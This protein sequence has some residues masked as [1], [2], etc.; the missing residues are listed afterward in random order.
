MEQR[1]DHP[2]DE[3][4]D[5]FPSCL[6]CPLPKCIEEAPK[7]RRQVKLTARNKEIVELRQK[8]APIEIIA[9]RYGIGR[10]MVFRILKRG[11]SWEIIAR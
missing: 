9:K 5:L 11:I 1:T 7:E 6:N 3:G 8:G 2:G 10:R 4:C